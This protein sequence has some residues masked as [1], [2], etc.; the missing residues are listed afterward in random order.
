M[1]YIPSST[2][3]SLNKKKENKNSNESKRLCRISQYIGFE[4]EA[5]RFSINCIIIDALKNANNH[6]KV[7]NSEPFGWRHAGWERN[8]RLNKHTKHCLII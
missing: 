6:V 2:I 3:K 8:A 1:H 5:L 7:I 4:F